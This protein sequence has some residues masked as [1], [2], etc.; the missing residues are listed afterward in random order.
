[1][2]I[3]IHMHTRRENAI[4]RLSEIGLLELGQVTRRCPGD[5]TSKLVS[6]FG[7]LQ[8]FWE[9]VELDR[10]YYRRHRGTLGSAAKAAEEV[11]FGPFVT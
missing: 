7:F 3:V 2:F 8:N 10:A 4:A 5:A 1:M 6:E 11:W 9:Q